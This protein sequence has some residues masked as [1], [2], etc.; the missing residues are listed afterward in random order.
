LSAADLT[1]DHLRPALKSVARIAAMRRRGMSET[2]IRRVLGLSPGQAVAA[3]LLDPYPMAPEVAQIGRLPLMI[4]VLAAV[5][6]AGHVTREAIL[7]TSQ[8]RRLAALRQLTIFLIREVCPGA[9]MYAISHFLMYH[10]T[11]VHFGCQQAAERLERD[12]DFC[13]LRDAVLRRLAG[14]RGGKR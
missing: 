13:D 11:T 4:D 5:A 12:A 14:L 10:H 6:D 3:G 8:R 2:A 1:F 9:T 7:G